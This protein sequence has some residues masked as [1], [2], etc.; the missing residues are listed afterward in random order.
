MDT[1]K[2]WIQA[3]MAHQQ[4][5]AVPYDFMFSPPAQRLLEQHYQ[6]DDI[7]G[8]IDLPM[9]MNAPVSIKPLYA[10]PAEFG[11]TVTDEF[12]V[13][14]STNEID[15][16][17]PVGS[18]LAEGNLKGYKFPDPAAG[19][20]FEGLEEWCQ[21]N[22]PHYTVIW[23]GDL[24]ERATFMR[25]MEHL[26]T[27]V[28]LAPAF[29]RD[30]LREITGYI[31]A[32]QEILFETCEFDAIAISDDYG[33]QKG[34]LMSPTDWRRLIK[35]FL[36]EIYSHAK[37]HC[38]ATFLHSCGNIYPVIG[39]L[40]DIGLDILHPIQPEAMDILQ[41]KREFGS[42][43]TFCGGV[44]TQ[45]LL[46]RGRPGD[47]RDEVRMLKREMGRGGGYILETGI[48]IQADVPLENMVA[49][50]EEAKAAD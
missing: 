18:C 41:L 17:S 49:L 26:L 12:G 2:Q 10:S 31:L 27:D 40:I 21:A 38:R 3:T 37:A 11:D 1:N 4:T 22:K 24:W 48:T 6:T 20:R 42:S 14:W 8:A 7:V 29:V 5:P 47:I 32:T 15:R 13:T 44:R 16:G 19:Y 36:A 45:D 30:L 43:L 46:P 33:S 25:G 50:I 9:R 35:P 23:T 39:D 28:A 34:M